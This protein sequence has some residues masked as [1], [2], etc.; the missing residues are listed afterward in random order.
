LIKKFELTGKEKDNKATPAY[1][2]P[3]DKPYSEEP[4]IPLNKASGRIHGT[5]IY[6]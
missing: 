6:G 3:G 2:V 1:Y 4:Q 5:G